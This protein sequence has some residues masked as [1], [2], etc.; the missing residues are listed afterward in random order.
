[1][2]QVIT[3]GQIGGWGVAGLGLVWLL[4]APHAGAEW[5]IGFGWLMQAG[6]WL[7]GMMQ[8]KAEDQPIDLSETGLRIEPQVV[9]DPLLADLP[10]VLSAWHTQI[11]VAG[12]LIKNNIEEMLTP[13]DVLMQR[14]AEENQ[15]G[16]SLFSDDREG[17]SITLIL[18][19]TN[20]TLS[21]V[22]RAF[23]GARQHKTQLQQTIGDL[24]HYMQELKNMA[25]AV[26]QLAS[27]TN[28]LSL[29][30]AIEAARAGDAGRG[31]AVVADEVRK[32]SGQ[33]GDTGRDIASKVEA[34]T[35]AIQA[36][37]NASETLV[38]TDDQNLQLLDQ[39]VQQVI[40]RLSG[41]ITQLHEEGKRLHQLSGD[42]EDAISQIIV[43][44]QFQDRVNQILEHLQTDL[45]ELRQI[46]QEE[47]SGTF[48]LA[49]W[50][51]NFRRRFTTDEEHLGRVHTG[52]SSDAVTFF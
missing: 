3:R 12:G 11:G 36:T 51:T 18:Q 21:D 4:M 28:L 46:M 45:I 37:I 35:Q 15:T 49:S 6:F 16:S 40:Q 10:A 1:M 22:I 14:L 42:S 29:N 39:T 30:A 38:K 34:V 47:L 13:F 52:S 20:R 8:T 24:S 48:D 50:E 31:F 5:L 26:Q 43:K 23:D 41:E 19:E 25:S 27:Q 44:M 17:Q 2:L 32:L 7:Y 33:S 9:A